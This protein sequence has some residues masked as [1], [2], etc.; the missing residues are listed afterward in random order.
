M[1][2][3][4][5]SFGEQTTRQDVTGV[6]YTTVFTHSSTNFV[7]SGKYLILVMGK[8]FGETANTT[9]VFCKVRHGSTDFA[10]SEMIYCPP[11]G[12]GSPASTFPNNYAWHTVWTAVSSEDITVQIR[13]GTAAD[14]VAMDQ[15]TFVAIRL[16]ADLTESTDWY[17]NVY[18]SD[19][20]SLTTSGVNGATLSFTPPASTDWLV[21][22][23]S[24][25]DVGSEFESMGTRI[26][27]TGTYAESVPSHEIET[28]EPGAGSFVVQTCIRVFTG[29]AA[30]TQ[31][32]TEQGFSDP[33]ASGSRTH[34]SIFALNLNKFEK[35]VAAWTAASTGQLGTTAWADAFQT[36]VSLTPDTAG[37]VWVVAHGASTATANV[38]EVIGRLQVDNTDQPAG[39]TEQ[40][41]DAY[42]ENSNEDVRDTWPFGIQT[43]ENLT[44]AAHTFDWE[45]HTNGGSS[46]EAVLY[47][48][49]FG[50]SLELAA[51]GPAAVAELIMAPQ[52]RVDRY[53][54]R[55]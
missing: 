33:S 54:G 38:R 52:A 27:S 46:A 51:G 9:E 16:D 4:A 41:T 47:R 25:C 19:P 36:G 6:T 3:I 13:G 53:R 55:P 37:D 48:Q 28:D 34:S 31:T 5:H 1:A 10:D 2:A 32:F 42:T 23:S 14:D 11:T 26:V 40:T 30:S 7:A 18:G 21:I 43:V 17:S 39:G 22:S 50:V 20:T 29:L 44:A 12:G 45:G 15:I 35:H 49:L 8:L 24:R